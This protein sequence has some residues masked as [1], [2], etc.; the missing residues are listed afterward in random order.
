MKI[1]INPVPV[2]PST[3]TTLLIAG[4]NIKKF[5]DSGEATISWQLLSDLDEVLSNGIVELSGEEYQGW[6][7]DSP[8]LEDLVLEKLGLTAT[9]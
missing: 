7:D 1:R 8:Y 5:A 4:A 9:T 3:A 2:F 6:N